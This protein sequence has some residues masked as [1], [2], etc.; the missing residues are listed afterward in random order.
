MLELFL[1]EYTAGR[2]HGIACN[3]FR[4]LVFFRFCGET[5]DDENRPPRTMEYPGNT[6]LIRLHADESN[7]FT[8]FRARYT[9][10]S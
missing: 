8:G 3:T 5:Q 6:L 4:M 2:G 7:E 1:I 9:I 10:H